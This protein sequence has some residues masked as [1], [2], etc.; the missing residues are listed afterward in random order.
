M[1]RNLRTIV[2]RLF[3]FL[4]FLSLAVTSQADVLQMVHHPDP[5]YNIP[6]AKD[7]LKG[8]EVDL[9]MAV[10]SQKGHEIQIKHVPYIR[11]HKSFESGSFDGVTTVQEGGFENAFFSNSYIQYENVYITLPE[12]NLTL[13]NIGSAREY[14]MASFRNA[15][16]YMGQEYAEVTKTMKN[17]V[18][19][20]KPITL[21]RL[22]Y[23]KRIDIAMIDRR[24]FLYF[25]KQADNVDTRAFPVFQYVFQPTKFQTA[26]KKKKYRDDFNQ[27]LKMIKKSGEYDQIIGKYENFL[28][29]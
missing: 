1:S 29:R 18:E 14:R 16:K 27:G 25:R 12:S 7:G 11:M 20:S 6:D 8:L 10:M 9:V 4:F 5:P 3:S 19:K 23:K 21:V 22:L 26:W 15:H 17:Y 24:I 28:K 13:P 2:I